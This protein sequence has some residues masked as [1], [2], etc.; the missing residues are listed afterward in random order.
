LTGSVTYN[1]TLT[2]IRVTIVAV[3]KQ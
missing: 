1:V 3:E 2:H